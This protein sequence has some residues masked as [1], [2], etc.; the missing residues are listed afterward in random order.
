VFRALGAG[1]VVFAC[2]G[3]G[4][5]IARSYRERPR[6]LAELSNAVRMLRAEIEYSLTPLPQALDKVARRTSKPVETLFGSAAERLVRGDTVADAFMV[7]VNRLRQLSALKRD[8]LDVLTEFASTLGLSD[9]AHQSQQLDLAL[10]RL[11]GLE[12]EAREMQR[13]NERMWQYLGVL[14]GLLMVV[15]LY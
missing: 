15:I 4:F 3:L 9:M 5:Q 13:K 14:L 2:A 10:H 1:L 7:A 12:T 8:D 6:Q 11:I